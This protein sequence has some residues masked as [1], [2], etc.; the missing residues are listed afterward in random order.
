M[1]IEFTFDWIWWYYGLVFCLDQLN[2]H[3]CHL[4][5]DVSIKILVKIL[6]IFKKIQLILRRIL[7]L[8]EET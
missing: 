1:K 5:I 7:I 3:K 4:Q 8:K 6:I 2:R